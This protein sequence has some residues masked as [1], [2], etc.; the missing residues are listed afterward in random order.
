MKYCLKVLQISRVIVRFYE[1][2]LG[3]MEVGAE[4]GTAPLKAKRISTKVYSD[5]M[6]QIGLFV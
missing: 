5:D 1:K 4:A 6:T 2:I 3:A